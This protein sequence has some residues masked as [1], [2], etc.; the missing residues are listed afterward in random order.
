MPQPSNENP[1]TMED[2]EMIVN[3]RSP[4]SNVKKNASRVG[5]AVFQNNSVPTAPTGQ[6]RNV[7]NNDDFDEEPGSSF[8]IT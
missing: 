5:G 6:T 2:D 8:M 7:R 4:P 1:M 3:V